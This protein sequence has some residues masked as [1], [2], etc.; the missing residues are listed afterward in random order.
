MNLTGTGDLLLQADAG[1]L[2][3][4][5]ASTKDGSVTINAPSLTIAGEVTIGDYDSS[6]D[7][8]ISLSATAGD[9]AIDAQVGNLL[10]GTLN[11]TPLSTVIQLS[12]V[13]GGIITNNSSGPGLLVSDSLSFSTQD[14][15]LLNTDVNLI[16]SGVV[17]SSRCKRRCHSDDS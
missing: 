2:T 9:L 8:V 11:R 3:I 6:R 4:E 1:S 10:D 7:H 17:S 15:V 13:S 16:T 14:S 5:G 12:A